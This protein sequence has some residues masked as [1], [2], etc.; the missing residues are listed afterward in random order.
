MQEITLRT[1]PEYT[2][3]SVLVLEKGEQHWLLQHSNLSFGD[4]L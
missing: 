2:A 1:D 3:V 4:G